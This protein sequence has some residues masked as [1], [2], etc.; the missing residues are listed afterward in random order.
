MLTRTVELHVM[1]K[2]EASGA[3]C[4]G[5]CFGSVRLPMASREEMKALIYKTKVRY[6][7]HEEEKW[8]QG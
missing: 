8:S 1:V 3:S 4:F 5:L 7:G 6:C 2:S